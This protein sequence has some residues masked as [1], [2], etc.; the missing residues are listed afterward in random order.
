MMPRAFATEAERRQT[1]ALFRASSERAENSPAG[2]REAALGLRQRA[3][4]MPDSC[5]RDA[6][7]RL[8]AKYEGR[9]NRGRPS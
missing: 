9:A 5:D 1:D 3:A 6:M 4:Q 8:A 2:M 7:L